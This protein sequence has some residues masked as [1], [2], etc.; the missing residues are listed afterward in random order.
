MRITVTVEKM[1]CAREETDWYFFKGSRMEEELLGASV[2][3]KGC[4]PWY[5]QDGECLELV[6]DWDAY[7]GVNHFKFTE[8][9]LSLPE[10][11]RAQC[12]Y[13]CSKTPGIG[14]SRAEALWAA[15]GADWR[16]VEVGDVPGIGV[17][18]IE[19]LLESILMFDEASQKAQ[20]LA[21]L[22]GVGCTKRMAVK[23]YAKWGA[24]ASGVVNDNCYSLTELPGI[25]FSTV[26]NHI[27]CFFDIDLMDPR[28]VEG[29]VIY[30]L[31][32]ELT[33]GSTAAEAKKHFN[34]CRVLLP[35]LSEEGLREVIQG[36]MDKNKLH[37]LNGGKMIAL[38]DDYCTEGLIYVGLG[39]MILKGKND[40]S[41]NTE[42]LSRGMDVKPDKSQLDAVE[43]AIC[44]DI[45]VITGG[46][47][48]GKTSTLRMVANGIKI[49][50]P[51]LKLCLC[52]PTGKAA[53]RLKE[54]SGI[55]ATTIH[56][57]LGASGVDSFIFRT[58]TLKGCAIIVDEASMVDSA[59]LR[60]ILIREP[61][62]LILVG[63]EAQLPPV[64]K[65]QPFHDIIKNYP[66][67]VKTLRCAYRNSEAVFQ[68]ASYIREG[69]APGQGSD[70]PN[71]RWSV[72]PCV[73]PEEAEEAIC[74][75]A[76]EGVMDFERDIILCPKN[77]EGS[78]AE[79]Y[80]AATVNSLNQKLLWIHRNM[81]GTCNGQRF[82][83]GDR[84]FNTKNFSKAGIWNGTTGTVHAVDSD[85]D[86]YVA[87]DTPVIDEKTGR[88]K[89]VQKF[90]KGQREH[91]EYAYALT[92]H[93][94]QGNQFRR[95]IFVALQRDS[96]QLDR[97]LLY[98]GVTRAEVEAIVV[99]DYTTLL[100]GIDRVNNKQTVLQCLST[101]D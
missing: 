35:D 27:R 4:I 66:A 92:V 50:N 63:D 39:R 2:V 99:G 83:I 7:K 32:Q 24:S 20:T 84:V 78:D 12:M 97:A 44:H 98:T 73:K 95:V 58:E 13:V 75:W 65:G 40:C 62:K 53:A 55:H 79:G 68:A 76:S 49:H 101:E 91:L 61:S 15:K 37:S 59:I 48:A 29:A 11:P 34:R 72:V 86:V 16:N 45:A 10:D 30:A 87:L 42:L 6:G 33:D 23:A 71:E 80:E 60:E 94:S 19:K 5:P 52:A 25:G 90:D 70:S 36:L 21:W 93:K 43:F 17:G 57:L 89:E 9:I 81:R 85:G 46:A 38:Q 47:G 54:T 28:R 14:T 74:Y 77:G 31:E 82:Q 8:A 100:K 1:L 22:E 18:S 67:I 69:K 96:Y 64:G 41:V 88:V 3:C 56:S 51:E 26:D